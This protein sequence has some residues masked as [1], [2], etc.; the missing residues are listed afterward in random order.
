MRH[1]PIPEGLSQT[2]WDVIIIGAGI[3]GTGIARDAA[4]R[5]L[6]VLLLEKEDISS[7]TS[8]W[9]SRLV[10]GG[11]RYLEYLEISLV[12]ESLSE[13]ERLLKN[14][15]HLVKP[16]Q[17]AIPF[18]KQNRRG[19]LLFR[20]GM[21]AYDVLSFDK[22]LDHHHVLN[23]KQV[24]EKIG[25]INP[26]G[27]RGA[28][29]YFDCQSEYAER[30]SVE[31]ALS[32]QEHGAVVI[33]Y[34]KVN[35]FVLEGNTVRG[36]EFTDLLEQKSY[37]VQAPVV[38]N[39]GGP[40][41]DEV[42]KGIGKPIKRL[43]GGTKGSHFVIDPFPG[44][45]KTAIYYEA[46]SDG[47]AI[48]VLP[49]TGRYLIGS[50]DLYYKDDLD[51]VRMDDDELDYLVKETNILFPSANLTP[52]KILYS[53]SGIRPL[54]YVEGKSTAAVTRRHIIYDHSPEVKGLISIV[55][56]KLTTFR[57]LAE[58]SVDLVYKKLGKPSPSC[59]THNLPLP[60]ADRNFE[61]FRRQFLAQSGLPDDIARHLVDVY[62]IRAEEVLDLADRTPELKNRLSPTDPTI[63][64]EVV[65]AFEKEMAETI[66]DVFLRRSMTAYNS[67][68]GFDALAPA[69][70]L[71][72]RH[73]GWNA[74]KVQSEIADYQKYIERYRPRALEPVG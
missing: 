45:P 12:R 60:G 19:P 32:A 13:R 50:T 3:N 21:L 5:G 27:L 31:N 39:V 38:I 16:L 46:R 54:P 44:A 22:S 14:A 25:A 15:P 66:N 61:A 65:F 18:Y 59:S 67:Q 64:A 37:T 34:A 24:F 42:L 70:E 6:K 35:R 29:M 53:Y 33:N 51:Y 68:V 1:H 11:L 69:A 73:L 30:L 62:G 28:A 10:H 43:I 20:M 63:G 47:R 74:A 56:G 57:N 41:V 55:G 26:D 23:N 58:Q 4:M 7:G 52:E 72:G 2:N 49:W 36:V 40:W 48:M 8:A 17:F 71:A 9:S